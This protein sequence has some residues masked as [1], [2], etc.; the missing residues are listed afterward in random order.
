MSTIANVYHKR[1]FPAFASCPLEGDLA[2]DFFHKVGP[3]TLPT[4]HW[5]LFAEVKAIIMEG[6]LRVADKSGKEFIMMY[7]RRT[8]PAL[9]P[10]P[11]GQTLAILYPTR[12]RMA[13]GKMGM[14]VWELERIMVS[15]VARL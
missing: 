14:G 2:S 10:F 4:R 6:M 13:S 15:L 3:Y 1:H 9:K 12:L 7:P 8:G 5:C 11:I